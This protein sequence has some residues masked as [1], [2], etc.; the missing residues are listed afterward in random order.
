VPLIFNF[1]AA[2]PVFTLHLKQFFLPS[3][4][5]ISEESVLHKINSLLWNG[6]K[7]IGTKFFK[8]A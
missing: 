8:F 2:I 1:S 7:F 4:G 3:W 6:K 5:W